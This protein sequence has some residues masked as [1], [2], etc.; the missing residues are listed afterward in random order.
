[1][2]RVFLK[3]YFPTLMLTLIKVWPEARSANSGE[4]KALTCRGKR[5][6][7]CDE[8]NIPIQ[9]IQMQRSTDIKFP[10]NNNLVTN[11]DARVAV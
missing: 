2:S 4:P 5:V 9:R 10:F 7:Q 11:A 8:T 6:Y 1:M 3:V